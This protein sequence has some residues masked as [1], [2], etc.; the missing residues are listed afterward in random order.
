MSSVAFQC[1]SKDELVAALAKREKDPEERLP[2]GGD[3][4]ATLTADLLGP[5]GG[6]SGRAPTADLFRLVLEMQRQQISWMED[7]RQEVWMNMQQ[8]IQRDMFERFWVQEREHV[9]TKGARWT[10]KLPRPMLQ[11]LSEKDD[12]ESYLEMF[13][14]VANQ[15]A[16]PKETW[17][18]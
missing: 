4:G 18:A 8:E 9:A 16:R 11:K 1:R 14:R 7:Q 13:E 3:S 12:V 6:D 10:T 15:Q 5:V 17:A 2:A